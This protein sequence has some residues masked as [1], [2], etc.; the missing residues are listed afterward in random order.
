[1]PERAGVTPRKYLVLVMVAVC[2]ALG[3]VCL[4]RGMKDFVKKF[5]DIT[6]SNWTD[7]FSALA[8]PWVIGGIIL[9]IGFMSAYLTALS[10]ADLT[11]VLPATALGYI[12]MALLARFF[13]LE[14]VTTKRWLGISLIVAGVGFVAGG[15][16][17]THAEDGDPPSGTA[18][19][20]GPR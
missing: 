3:D 4:S 2:G 14:N 15:P 8:S 19:P 17:M 13:L 1:M 20:E 16:A 10:W 12:V 9:L 7:L 6:V 5:G 18:T 11:Y